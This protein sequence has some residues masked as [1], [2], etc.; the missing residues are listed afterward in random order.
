MRAACIFSII[1]LLLTGWAIRTPAQDFDA[2]SVYYT[3]IERKMVSP[4]KKDA[5]DKEEPHTRAAQRLHPFR[6]TLRHQKLVRYF[7]DVRV[8]T[9]EACIDCPNNREITLTAAMVHGVTLG[10]KWR[11]GAG[12]GYDKYV[13]W[14]VLPVF[15]SV[16]YD[17]L[18]TRNTHALFV[19]GLYGYGFARPDTNP[20]GTTRTDD[21]GGQMFS[22]LAGF[23]FR[24][25][26]CGVAFAAGFKQQK[27][28]ASYTYDRWGQPVDDGPLP[29]NRI[30]VTMGRGVV[31][32]IFSWR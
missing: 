22:A 12:A 26:K 6:D 18:G 13:G 8:G 11:I 31:M 28:F 19:Q 3:P 24:V 17:I 4:S 27:A 32:M 9:L 16:S 29:Y 20:W 10:R 30:D 2:D 14:D 1:I 23:R 21:G 7:M 5:R 15:G 25:R